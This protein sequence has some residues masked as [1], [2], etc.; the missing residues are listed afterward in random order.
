MLN[1]KDLNLTTLKPLFRARKGKGKIGIVYQCP[2][3]INMYG[4]VYPKG[5]WILFGKNVK[6][7]MTQREF[8]KNK[9]KILGVF[10]HA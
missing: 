7:P 6:Y 4:K 10:R 1:E 2:E 8:E 3:S 5:S 9:Y